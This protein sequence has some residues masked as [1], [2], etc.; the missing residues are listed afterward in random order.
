MQILQ[1]QQY[2]KT[3]KPLNVKI[4][5]R[6]LTYQPDETQG[7]DYK[8]AR[9]YFGPYR[10]KSVDGVNITAYF[11]DRPD[12]EYITVHLDRVYTCPDELSNEVLLGIKSKQ[13][14]RGTQR[15][16]R[17]PKAQDKSNNSNQSGIAQ[18]G[19]RPQT[20]SQVRINAIQ[21]MDKSVLGNIRAQ[22]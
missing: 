22:N 13:H 9:P 14:R 2:D 4:G 11:V 10:V 7:K 5:D 6:V 21:I 12:S 20:R 19:S 1:K 15:S 18:N 16:A 17:Y 3:A 8:F